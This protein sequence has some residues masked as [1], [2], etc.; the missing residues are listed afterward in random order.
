MVL[1]TV[2]G[3][4][5]FCDVKHTFPECQNVVALRWWTLLLQKLL[6]SASRGVLDHDIHVI[7]MLKA[8]IESKQIRSH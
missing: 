2:N 4:K 6:Q 8:S 7:A 3:L 5:T 1:H